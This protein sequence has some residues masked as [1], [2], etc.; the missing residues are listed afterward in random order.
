MNFMRRAD[1]LLK[2]MTALRQC[3]EHCRRAA[4]PMDALNERLRDL[5]QNPDL[6]DADIEEIEST[7]RRALAAYFG[8]SACSPT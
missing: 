6:S 3:V 4:S 8:T 7:A 5:R 1:H 2:T